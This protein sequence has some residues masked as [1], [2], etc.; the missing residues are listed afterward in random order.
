MGTEQMQLVTLND[1]SPVTNSWIVAEVFGKSHDNVLRDIRNLKTDVA[2][3]SAEEQL[4]KIEELFDG[5]NEK[6]ERR[7][8]FGEGAGKLIGE[9]IHTQP[10]TAYDLA[11]RAMFCTV[12]RKS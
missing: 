3:W 12:L 11:K 6:Q 2:K 5:D 4:L 8:E 10:P 9:P 1:K 7:R